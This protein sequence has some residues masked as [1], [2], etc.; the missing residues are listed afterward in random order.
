MLLL[1]ALTGA[2]YLLLALG[3][4][5]ASTFT[6]LLTILLLPLRSWFG[7]FPLDIPA[8]ELIR[9]A[10]DLAIGTLCIPVLWAALDS[11]HKAGPSQ[12]LKTSED[13]SAREH[14]A[15]VVVAAA[16]AKALAAEENDHLA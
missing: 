14:K 16:V 4:F 5:G 11:G 9:I 3:L 8:W 2:V 7:L 1:T 15:P 12:T 6:L 10:I 13:S